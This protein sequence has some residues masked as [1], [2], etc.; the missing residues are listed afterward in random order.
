MGNPHLEIR[1]KKPVPRTNSLHVTES[2]V[3]CEQDHQ[4][5]YFVLRYDV[6]K[7]LELNDKMLT[8]K[9]KMKRL[10]PTMTKCYLKKFTVCKNDML[11]KN[12]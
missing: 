12:C 3:K 5:A 4:R 9:I 6:D 1:W 2:M 7:G 11:N 10:F 8:F